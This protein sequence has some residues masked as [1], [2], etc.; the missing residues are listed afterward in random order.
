M[1][2]QAFEY[3]KEHLQ[4]TDKAGDKPCTIG[5]SRIGKGFCSFHVEMQVGKPD[6][7]SNSV[8]DGPE[9]KL[10]TVCEEPLRRFF[11]S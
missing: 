4:P 10:P 11:V 6:P 8:P 3:E 5:L 2:V 7:L 9:S 1:V